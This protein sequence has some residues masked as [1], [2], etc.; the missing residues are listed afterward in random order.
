MNLS[1][2]VPRELVVLLLQVRVEMSI[3][4]SFAVTKAGQ[5]NLKLKVRA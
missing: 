1:L 5:R 2:K 4:G 3:K